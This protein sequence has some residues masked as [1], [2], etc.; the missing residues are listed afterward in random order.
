LTAGDGKGKGKAG[1][2][3]REVKPGLSVLC[4]PTH[5]LCHLVGR[6]RL[7]LSNPR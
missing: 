3:W 4:I 7:T 1:I 2:K 6:C 5:L